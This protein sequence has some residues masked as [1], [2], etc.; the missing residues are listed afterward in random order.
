MCT[1]N[2]VDREI[3]C[4]ALLAFAMNLVWI[5][6]DT[7]EILPANFEQGVNDSVKIASRFW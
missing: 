3:N 2:D 5:L 1:K 6:P 7:S 4:L